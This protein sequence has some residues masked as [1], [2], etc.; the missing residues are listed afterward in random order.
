M[1]L[2]VWLVLTYLAASFPF[3]LWAGLA[4]AG[5]DPRRA[6]SR[7]TGAT[8]VARLCGTKCGVLV[9]LLD[10]LKGLLPV[11]VGSA[12]SDSWIFLSLVGLAALLG[13][14]C[15]VFLY[16]K[17][18]KGVATTIGVFL[19]YA[20]GAA[21]LAVAACTLVIWR[22]GYVSAGSLT[23]V[24]AMPLTLVLTG[25]VRYAPV[26]LVVAAWVAWRHRENI[27]RLAAGQEKGWRKKA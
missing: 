8:N 10:L 24:G 1:V 11:V 19:A 27:G 5:V 22:T 21:L 6:G 25:N 17:G 20:P 26:A 16:G 3:G 2:V 15:S 14:M 13:H 9:L 7:N 12:L 23:L 18:G 4:L